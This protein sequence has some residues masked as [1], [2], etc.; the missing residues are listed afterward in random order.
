[1]ATITD[2]GFSASL[3]RALVAG[4]ATADIVLGV[5]FL[6]P[7][8]V[9][10]AGAAMLVLSVAYLMGLSAIAPGLWT[11]HFGPLLKVVPMMAAV[12]VVMAYQEKR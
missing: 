2:A 5:L 3:A 10:R 1:M 8:W 9:R 4:A 12:L 7:G 6:V 11:E